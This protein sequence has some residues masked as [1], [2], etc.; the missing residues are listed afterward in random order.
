MKRVC[1]GKLQTSLCITFY[2]EVHPP[3]LLHYLSELNRFLKFVKNLKFSRI[4]TFLLRENLKT[5]EDFR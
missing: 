2:I 1:F 5:F 4:G 3:G